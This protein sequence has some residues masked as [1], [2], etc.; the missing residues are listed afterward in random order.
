MLEYC[1]DKSLFSIVMQ[2]DQLLP[3]SEISD[4]MKMLLSAVAY[5]SERHVMHRDIKLEN[6]VMKA[7]CPKIIDF[8]CC[9]Q[10]FGPRRTL[11]GTTE[12]LCPEMVLGN[13]YDS[14]VDVYTLGVLLYELLFQRSPFF[15]IDEKEMLRNI[16]EG[17]LL[18]EGPRKDAS[19]AAKDIVSQMLV[20]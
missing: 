18:F 12:Y 6:V 20:Q 14:R 11:C 19:Q 10:T 2:A 3:E 9:I 17:V 4:I 8:G 7:G 5:M 15:E 1:G 13:E 16:K